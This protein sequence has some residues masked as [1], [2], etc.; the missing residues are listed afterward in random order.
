MAPDNGTGAESADEA[1]NF[2]QSHPSIE[3]ER[4][5]SR[6]RRGRIYNGGTVGD[7]VINI[8]IISIVSQGCNIKQIAFK[9]I[10]LSSSN[11]HIHAVWFIRD[12]P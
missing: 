5:S 3:L 11:L 9:L 4:R 10:L 8:D 2:A 12:M 1:T 7:G 6:T